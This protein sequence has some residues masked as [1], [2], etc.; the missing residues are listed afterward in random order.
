MIRNLVRATDK[1]EAAIAMQPEAAHRWEGAPPSAAPPTLQPGPA[2]LTMISARQSRHVTPAML[3]ALGAAVECDEDAQAR[4]REEVENFVATLSPS[5]LVAAPQYD[6]STLARDGP[7]A[8]IRRFNITPQDKFDGK[9]PLEVLYD[10][11]DATAALDQT[12]RDEVPLHPRLPWMLEDDTRSDDQADADW[13]RTT[14]TLL[15]DPLVSIT[16]PL[17]FTAGSVPHFVRQPSTRI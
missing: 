14:R 8:W 6:G 17:P 1:Y 5:R 4:L 15:G 13:R 2:T 12:L 10:R 9:S 7:D 3:S 11:R 16:N